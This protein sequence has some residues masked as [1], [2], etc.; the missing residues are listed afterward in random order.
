MRPHT[1]LLLRRTASYVEHRSEWPIQITWKLH[2]P[3][4]G[5]IFTSYRAAVV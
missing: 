3:L 1:A 4:P 5:D 2:H